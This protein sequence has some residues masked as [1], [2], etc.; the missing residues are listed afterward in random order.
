VKTGRL[1]AL[2]QKMLQPISY[3]GRLVALATPNRFLLSGSLAMRAVGDPERTFVI[4]MCL[5]AI[6]VLTGALPAPYTEH[7]ARRYA[8]AA[9]IPEELLERGQ[10]NYEVAS[11]A[12]GVPAAE[13]QDA[14]QANQRE[15]LRRIG[16]S[17]MSDEHT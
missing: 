15:R 1:N 11:Q 6:D 16:A 12:L 4:Y 7:R 10:L 13:L 8:R 14:Y 2:K 9:L 3:R 17:R 5:Y